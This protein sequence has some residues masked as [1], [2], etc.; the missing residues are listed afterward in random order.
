MIANIFSGFPFM[1]FSCWFI[2]G[3]LFSYCTAY[4]FHIPIA[5][6]GILCLA[7]GGILF[8]VSNSQP[9]KNFFLGIIACFFL[10]SLGV[11]ISYQSYPL[12]RST[13]FSHLSDVQAFRAVAISNGERKTLG[14]KFTAQVQAVRTTSG[15]KHTEG[16]I[17]I[18]LA[19]TVLY[20]YGDEFLVRGQPQKVLPA[21]NPYQFDYKHYL[22]IQGIFHQIS[23]QKDNFLLIGNTPISQIQ[24]LSLQVR[25]Y[26]D[27][28][29]KKYV[30]HKEAYGVVAALLLG[31]KSWL[32]DE[33]RQ[34]YS[35]AGAMHVLAV[36]GLHV[37]ILY[38][39]IN[40][41]LGWTSRFTYG[42]LLKAF[43]AVSLLWCYA[44]VTGL[45]PSVLRAVTMFSLVVLAQTTKRR[46]NIYNTIALS[47][48]ILL[49]FNPFL[50]FQV[51]FQLSYLAVLGIIYFQPKF[52][53]LFEFENRFA[54]YLWQITCVAFAATLVT[55]PISMYYFG[56]FP[57]LFFISNILVVPLAAF[58]LVG[59][60]LIVGLSG[61]PYV[62]VAIG[63]LV[64]NVVLIQN[65]L[66]KG[67][68]NL[69][70]SV[71]ENIHFSSFETLLFYLFVAGLTLHWFHRLWLGVGLA[72]ISSLTYVVNDGIIKY[73]QAQENRLWVYDIRQGTHVSF[74]LG[75]EAFNFADTRLLAHRKTID[76]V[77]RAHQKAIGVKPL[78]FRLD[79]APHSPIP[80]KS[81]A[82]GYLW[83]C[84]QKA[85]FM[86]KNQQGLSFPS[87][88]IL[89]NSQI[90]SIL[91][92]HR[93]DNSV[94]I[95]DISVR[96]KTI[97]ALKHI[98]PAEKLIS[99]NE[100]GAINLPLV[101]G[102]DSGG[103]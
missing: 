5:C 24:A 90:K 33:V 96:P 10:T 85:V 25:R 56:Q 64:K 91:S 82:D 65:F 103:K 84:H 17:L 83:V 31:V 28:V 89:A 93:V 100:K 68:V 6:L 11:E 69:P 101:S 1:R 13:H 34:T 94:C 38:A 9:S 59:S 70:Y 78:F 21:R 23:V 87:N 79:S 62:P 60:L 47:A 92:K 76:N 50:L 40:L 52:Y 36:S 43:I 46:S 14:Q 4:Q 67:L 63:F 41:V 20:R 80:Y 86:P 44:F 66:L 8:G 39:L 22:A 95:A 81:L 72:I 16:K 88:I 97:A 49:F 51:G 12:N 102:T 18:Q 75:G 7:Y 71:I 26:A 3:I 19:D 37:G 99:I 73:A 45:S 53:S 61:L 74:I 77:I 29:L 55:A 57:T 2:I 27:E 48:F 35:D 98:F 54:D 32:T 58:L 42:K 30:D 15:W